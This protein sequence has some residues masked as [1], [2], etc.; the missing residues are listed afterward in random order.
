MRYAYLILAHNNWQQ[1]RRLIHLLDS[2]NADFYI[3]IDRRA[4]DFRLSEFENVCQYSGAYFYSEF[5]N[6]W[7]SYRLVESELL[8]LEKATTKHYDYY[9]LLSGTDLP[10]K[11]RAYVED[12]FAKNQGKEFIHFDTDERLRTDREIGRRAR[13]YHWLQ[14]YR[15]RFKANWLNGMFTFIEHCSL[16][17]QLA[18]RVDRLKGKNIQIYYGS[19]WF[20]ITDDFAMYVLSRRELIAR[21]FQNTSCSDELAFQT[22]IMQSDFKTR[23]YIEERNNSCLSNMR[24]IDWKRGKNGS[25]YTWKPTDI[26]ELKKS[27]CL[28]ARKFPP[29]FPDDLINELVGSPMCEEA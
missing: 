26:E 18:L 5:E 21:L 22:I 7:G 29:D 17:I 19:Q 9:H 10:I 28:F 14:N 13:L 23:L 12:F 25:P 6:Y 27:E 1:L 20:S 3:H 15:R 4:K 8:L 2:P 11:P 24:L 16:G